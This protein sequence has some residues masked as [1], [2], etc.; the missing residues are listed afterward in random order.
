MRFSS[1]FVFA[2]AVNPGFTNIPR[3]LSIDGV[4]GVLVAPNIILV[5]DCYTFGF[6]LYRQQWNVSALE[7]SF[8]NVPI[9]LIETRRLQLSNNRI[10]LTINATTLV[11]GAEGSTDGLYSCRVCAFDGRCQSTSTTITIFGE[12]CLFLLFAIWYVV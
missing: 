8:N 10:Q 4:G 2:P 12:Y 5:L 7:W 3:Y 11:S 9:G 1:I 6:R